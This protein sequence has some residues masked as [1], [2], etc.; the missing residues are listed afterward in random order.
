MKRYVKTKLLRICKIDGTH[1]EFALIN[2]LYVVGRR[3]MQVI[4]QLIIQPVT[5][6][7]TNTVAAHTPVVL[8]TTTMQSYSANYILRYGPKKVVGLSIRNV[9]GH[10]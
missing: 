6:C 3:E 9:V 5:S 2:G 8:P 1:I 10:R 4:I 7:K